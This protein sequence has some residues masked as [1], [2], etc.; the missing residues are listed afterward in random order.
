MI[1]GEGARPNQAH[2]AAHDV[3]ELGQ[4]IEAAAPEQPADQ[5]QDPRIMGQ[6]EE[7][8]PLEPC[9]R[10]AREV[11][12]QPGFRIGVHRAQLAQA[13]VPSVH[14]H[15]VLEV[16]GRSGVNELD[17]QRREGDEGRNNH[18]GWDGHQKVD[19]SLQPPAPLPYLAA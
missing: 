1:G 13:N 4:F 7:A 9:L 15:P 16:E 5:W 19:Q 11:G 12:L 18:A 6:L 14:A 8:L 10:I 3:P 2:V 17:G